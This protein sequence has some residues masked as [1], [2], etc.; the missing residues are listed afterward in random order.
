VSRPAI[1]RHL[2]VLERAG[3]IVRSREGSVAAEPVQADRSTRRWKWMQSRKQTWRPGWTNSKRTCAGKESK[4]SDSNPEPPHQEVLITRIFEARPR[5]GVQGL[6]RPDEVSHGTGP[7]HMKAPRE[8]IHIDLRVVA[9]E[10]RWSSA[11]VMPSSHR[12]RD[13]ELVEPEL[14]VLRS[15]PMPEVGMP[16]PRSCVWEFHDHGAKTRIR[17]ATGPTLRQRTRRG[18]VHRR[19]RQTRGAPRRIGTV[20]R[21]TARPAR[22]RL[23]GRPPITLVNPSETNAERLTVIL[24]LIPALAL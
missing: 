8:R 20:P 1:S 3:L 22:A 16:S 9:L 6:D 19:L 12:L 18:W 13:L 4:M 23:T 17:S 24:P 5:T 14:I 15:D 10:R 21:G 11:G 2:K 7:E